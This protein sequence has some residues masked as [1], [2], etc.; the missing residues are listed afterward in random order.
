MPA[1]YINDESEFDTL[2]ATG[3]T[4]VVDC[5]ANWCGPCKIVGPLIDR[6]ADEYPDQAKVLKLDLDKNKAIAKRF[7]ISSIPAVM[8]F[9]EGELSAALIGVKPYE[10]FSEA[11]ERLL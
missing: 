10:D 1:A 4:M 2:L 3:S 6:L 9:K 5:T 11:L 8:Y 7:K